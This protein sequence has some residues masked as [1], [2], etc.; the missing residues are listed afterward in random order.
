MW[1]KLPK[2]SEYTRR[3]LDRSQTHLGGPETEARRGSSLW[4]GLAPA[5][6]VRA[7]QMFTSDMLSLWP[8][9]ATSETSAAGHME[10]TVWGKKS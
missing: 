9:P 6:A 8:E 10:A 2:Y 4:A 7:V 1:A 5:V 3:D